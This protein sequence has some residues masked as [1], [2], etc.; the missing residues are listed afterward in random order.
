MAHLLEHM[1]F[2]GT[3]SNPR[4]DQDMQKRGAQINGTTWLDRTNYYETLPASDDNL[5]YAI[6]LEADRMINSTIKGEDLASEMT[7]VRNEFERG[8]DSPQRILSQRMHAVAFEW[9]N[10]GK[11]TIGNRSDI[12]RVPLPRL[13][14]FYRKHYQPDNALLVIAGQFDKE[15]ALGYVSKYFGAIPRPERELDKTYTDEPAQ[16]GERTVALRRV[17]ET[18]LV[19][20]LYHIPASAHEDFAPI[21]VMATI[22]AMEPAGRLYKTLIETKKASSMYGYAYPLHDPAMV[23]FL[24][25]VRKDGSLRDVQKTLIETVEG[26][27]KDGVKK[28]EVDRKSVV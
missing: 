12:E 2:K 28:E 17:G 24:A 27:G 5:E 16:D 7:V 14:E 25:E 11:S 8:E 1:L 10:Y 6:R 20:V 26:V 22:L 21:S 3:P 18:G 15:K 9:H 4:I 23:E 13:R 19:G